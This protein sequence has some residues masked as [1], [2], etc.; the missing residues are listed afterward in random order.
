MQGIH[1]QTNHI[2]V[3]LKSLKQK[4]DD[5]VTLCVKSDIQI[6]TTILQFLQLPIRLHAKGLFLINNRTFL[7]V[8][9]LHSS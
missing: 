4:T 9:S 2:D 1:L 7:E 6:E 8:H 3:N 5:P